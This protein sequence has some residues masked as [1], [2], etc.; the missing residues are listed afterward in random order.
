MAE[1][2][3][4]QSF[5]SL[6]TFSAVRSRSIPPLPASIPAC[7]STTRAKPTATRCSATFPAGCMTNE[8]GNASGYPLNA[9]V[10]TALPVP[11]NILADG[12]AAAL[13]AF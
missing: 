12:G 5:F 3:Y 11:I 1:L 6:A 10:L 2:A 8:K 4:R 9:N 13:A 7:Q